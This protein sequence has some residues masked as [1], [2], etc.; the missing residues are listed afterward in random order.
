MKN[1]LWSVV[2]VGLNARPQFIG[3]LREGRFDA[4]LLPALLHVE[5]FSDF[6]IEDDGHIA[7]PLSNGLLVDEPLSWPPKYDGGVSDLRTI[8]L[9]GSGSSQ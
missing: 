6:S 5:Q 2:T 7:L 1:R 4:F 9:Q 3:E 8:L